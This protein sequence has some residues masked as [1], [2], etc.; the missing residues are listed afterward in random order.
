M[1]KISNDGMMN[2][3]GRIL[4]FSA[5]GSPSGLRSKYSVKTRKQAGFTLLELLVVVAIIGILAA[6]SIPAIRGMTKSQ[7][8]VTADR[9]LLDDIA[10]ARARAIAQH[11]TVYMVFVPPY[12]INQ[13]IPADKGIANQYS[14]L[15]GGQFTTYALLSIRSVGEQPGRSNPRYLT[16]WKALPNGTYIPPN[17]FFAYDPNP[18][19]PDAQ[20]AFPTNSFPFPFGTNS[21]VMLPYI[22]FDYLGRLVSGKDEYLPLAHGSIFYARDANGAFIPQAADVAEL[23]PGNTVYA[24]T[25]PSNNYNQIHIEWLTGRAHVEKQEVQ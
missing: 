24:P 17:K 5:A 19:I 2:G 13:P 21:G 12:I 23:P 18:S 8:T 14:N 3:Q 10:N 25:Y 7:A 22:A 1:Q 16:P 20:R 4:N 9:Q 11:T 6:I 15:F